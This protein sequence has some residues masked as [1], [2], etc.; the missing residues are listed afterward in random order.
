M[1]DS[2]ASDISV[3]ELSQFEEIE[4]KIL[5]GKSVETPRTFV[6]PK[7][8]RCKAPVPQEDEDDLNTS[9]SSEDMNMFRL[10][11]LQ[12]LT[13]DKIQQIPDGAEMED[14]DDPIFLARNNA[15]SGSRNPPDQRTRL[16]VPDAPADDPTDQL[17]PIT[18]TSEPVASNPNSVSSANSTAPSSPCS[19]LDVA[20]FMPAFFTTS[21]ASTLERKSQ[22]LSIKNRED[23]EV[24]LID[25]EEDDFP[26]DPVSQTPRFQEKTREKSGLFPAQSKS[27]EQLA[28]GS[29]TVGHVSVESAKAAG[30]PVIAAERPVSEAGT[31]VQATGYPLTE[32]GLPIRE[33]TDSS[34]SAS[35]YQESSEVFHSRKL[36]QKGTDSRRDLSGFRPLALSSGGVELIGYAT[37]RV[38]GR[39]DSL[40]TS[41]VLSPALTRGK[42]DDDR[43]EAALRTREILAQDSP[44]DVVI[45]ER[46]LSNPPEASSPRDAQSSQMR[47]NA[48]YNSETVTRS[49]KSEVYVFDFNQDTVQHYKNGR[50][51]SAQ[52]FRT[53]K[54]SK[55]GGLAESEVPQGD[56]RA[57]SFNENFANQGTQRFQQDAH[58]GTYNKKPNEQEHSTAGQQQTSDSLDGRPR[59]RIPGEARMQG[60]NIKDLRQS[61][62]FST[63]RKDSTS[64]I[65]NG[66]VGPSAHALDLR[67]SDGFATFR[68]GAPDATSENM[69]VVSTHDH[70]KIEAKRFSTFAKSAKKQS[71]EHN[72][73]EEGFHHFQRSNTEP[74]DIQ[75]AT[76]AAR[77][78]YN[79]GAEG[80]RQATPRGR[81][82]KQIRVSGSSNI[83]RS[84]TFR[85]T[86]DGQIID[87]RSFRRSISSGHERDHS[88]TSSDSKLSGQQTVVTNIRVSPEGAG[89]DNPHRISWTD[90]SEAGVRLTRQLNASV[91][92][93]V[94][95]NMPPPP[96][97]QKKKSP[98]HPSPPS[99]HI[100]TH[101]LKLTQNPIEKV[102]QQQYPSP[103][104]SI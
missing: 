15:A 29:Y 94:R 90:E 84:R 50:T 17:S 65:N 30:I 89:S 57:A 91:D 104:T 77:T 48:N 11:V 22:R 79:D 34:T 24:T 32:T 36:S 41:P 1:R 5:A 61:D 80:E 53:Y 43:Q 92:R 66:E 46:S 44:S 95:I 10:E 40:E 20:P 49:N 58:S 74:T 35:S 93:S 21:P 31:P 54:K 25:E 45:F 88:A 18:E 103:L 81:E 7:T 72:Y 68:K 28:R 37:E 9:V 51:A 14:D 33:R 83:A 39:R 6:K 64:E 2:C 70:R 100:H 23:T 8:K 56:R 27:F 62:G 38:D 47:E 101:T 3:K 59:H 4:A 16:E 55:Q 71:D 52:D 82:E 19:P 13:E 98:C 96:H 102:A 63:F 97:C 69:S 12:R 78:P 67:R 42:R 87:D 76:M 26:S 75:Q 86:P 73:A 85:K 60:V 99:T